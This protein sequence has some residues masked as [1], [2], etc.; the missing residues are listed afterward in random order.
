MWF[1]RTLNRPGQKLQYLFFHVDWEFKILRIL[2]YFNIAYTKGV[3]V[4]RP[5]KMLPPNL[6]TPQNNLNLC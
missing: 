6:L 5:Q 4:R 3:L 1:G 2:L